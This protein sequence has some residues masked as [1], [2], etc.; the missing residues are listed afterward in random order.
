MINGLLVPD[1]NNS[2]GI[3]LSR[4]E[5]DQ[6]LPFNDWFTLQQLMGLGQSHDEFRAD[7]KWRTLPKPGAFDAA[8]V[9]DMYY[10]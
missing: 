2:V 5:S 8:V 10:K 6:P 7:L 9:V 4:A 3:S 1:N